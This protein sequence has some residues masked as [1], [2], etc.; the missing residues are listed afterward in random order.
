MAQDTL[1]KSLP[2]ILWDGWTA[3]DRGKVF[4]GQWLQL[5]KPLSFLGDEL[6]RPSMIFSPMIVESGKQLL[7]SDLDV[8]GLAAVEHWEAVELF[9]HFPEVR[10]TFNIRNAVRMKAHFSLYLTTRFVADQAD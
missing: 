9:A 2:S 3:I 10:K 4:E 7:I 8:S 6:F 5:R 1:E